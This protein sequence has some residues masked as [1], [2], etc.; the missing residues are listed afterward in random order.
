MSELKCAC[1]VSHHPRH[2]GYHHADCWVV[3]LVGAHAEIK[4]LQ[5]WYG[6]A[7]AIDKGVI[8]R[9]RAER[10]RLRAG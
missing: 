1:P 2:R 8:D 7:N 10:D 6:H 4:R 9:L 3:S 5:E